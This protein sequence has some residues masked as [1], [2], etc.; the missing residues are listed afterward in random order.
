M[1]YS[2]INVCIRRFKQR[3]LVDN[4]FE[5]R[6]VYLVTDNRGDK[7]VIVRVAGRLFDVEKTRSNVRL[8][9]FEKIVLCKNVYRGGWQLG[10]AYL[11][12]FFQTF[13]KV[14]GKV[15]LDCI[16]SNGF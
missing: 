10:L 9:P 15:M 8:S 3:G 11:E 1:K 4:K 14:L 5:H 7:M 16:M 12:S 6:N 13:S 2:F